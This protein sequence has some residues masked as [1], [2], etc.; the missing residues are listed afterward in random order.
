MTTITPMVPRILNKPC[1]DE[2]VQGKSMIV[3]IVQMG[4]DM[5]IGMVTIT[6]TQIVHI[7]MIRRLALKNVGHMKYILQKKILLKF[8]TSSLS[9]TFES[10]IP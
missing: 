8:F 4:R 3:N 6:I 1:V 7:I 2:E 10:S 9:A 5:T